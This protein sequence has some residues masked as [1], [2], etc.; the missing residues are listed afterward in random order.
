MTLFFAKSKNLIELN[1]LNSLG[2]H[3]SP[4]KNVDENYKKDT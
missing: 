1:K 4:W 2:E 3:W